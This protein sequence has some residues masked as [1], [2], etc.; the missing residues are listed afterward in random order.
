MLDA[1]VIR[2]E[3]K[4]RLVTWR[5]LSYTMKQDAMPQWASGVAAAACAH[6]PDPSVLLETFVLIHYI[7]YTVFKE[8]PSSTDR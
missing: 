4:D 8:N 5:L 6:S 2:E 1:A 7:G 3:K